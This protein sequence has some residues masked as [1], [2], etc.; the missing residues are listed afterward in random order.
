M[1]QE[2]GGEEVA[3]EPDAS[4]IDAGGELEPE[5]EDQGGEPAGEAAGEPEPESA[6]A[7]DV[8]EA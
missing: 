1:E 4:E 8:P 5:G 7:D 3:V 2:L 6:D